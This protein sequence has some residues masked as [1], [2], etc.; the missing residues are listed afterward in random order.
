MSPSRKRPNGGNGGAG[1]NVYVVADKDLT[2]MNFRTYHFN[3][4]DGNNG[5]SKS[6]SK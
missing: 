3:A 2:G 1:G 6:I 4:G 5:G